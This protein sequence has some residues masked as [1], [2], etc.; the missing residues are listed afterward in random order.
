MI[1]LTPLDVRNKRSD[2]KK[3]LRGYDPQEVDVF[4]QLVAERMEGLVRETIQLRERAE[5]L[6]RQVSSSS[7]RER[8]V[9][10]ALVTAQE[11][12]ADIRASA[13][14]EA[15]LVVQGAHAEARG[16][17]ADAER[18]LESM[19]DSL[20]EV[21]RRRTRFLKNFRQL[22]ERELDDVAVEESRTPLEE[23][24][25]ELRLGGGRE[26]R[27]REG[28][29]GQ[30]MVPVPPPET[31]AEVP[32]EL[33]P[34]RPLTF[35]AGDAEDDL[36]LDEVREMEREKEPIEPHLPW[37]APV[38]ELAKAIEEGLE[39]AAG[40]PPE[41]RHDRDLFSLP[42]LSLPDP[43]TPGDGRGPVGR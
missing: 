20:I 21:E 23:R 9:Q 33:P 11:L 12:R 30:V 42:D 39:R 3:I 32:H 31:A 36:D 15:E 35:P 18:R 28:P 25:I 5:T 41:T 17:I 16:I 37:D 19:K 26:E 7:G 43:P 1:D 2:F 24:A 29:E 6:Q 34:Q 8:A 27:E 10:E 14:R 4:L 13:Q 40:G 22:L 38:H